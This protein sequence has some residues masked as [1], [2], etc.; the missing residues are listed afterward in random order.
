MGVTRQSAH[1][2]F[3]AA[4][5]DPDTLRTLFGHPATTATR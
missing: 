3:A 2:R 5:E 4:S 1:G